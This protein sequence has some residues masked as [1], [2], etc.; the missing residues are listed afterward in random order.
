MIPGNEKT[1]QTCRHSSGHICLKHNDFI[2]KLDA[3]KECYQP[4]D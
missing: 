1:C 2:I 4:E 3:K